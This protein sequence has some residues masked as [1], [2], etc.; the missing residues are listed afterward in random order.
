[1]STYD[2]FSPNNGAIHN[3]AQILKCVMS[4][5]AEAELGVLYL[6]AKQAVMM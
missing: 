6:N 2:T 1:M 3:T 5:V 4:T